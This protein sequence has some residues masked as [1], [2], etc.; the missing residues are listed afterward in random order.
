MSIAE[1]MRAI[2]AAIQAEG[3]AARYTQ[4][5]QNADALADMVSWAPGI[6]DATGKLSDHLATLQQELHARHDQT[7]DAG[8]AALHDALGDLRN[9]IARHDRDFEITR[10]DDT[11]EEM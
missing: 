4:L 1:L 7:P 8:L 2:A 11:D 3:P 9:A 6:I 10:E 5:A